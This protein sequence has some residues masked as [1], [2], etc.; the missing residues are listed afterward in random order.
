[1]VSHRTIIDYFL[2]GPDAVVSDSTL[3][4]VIAACLYWRLWTVVIVYI[5]AYLTATTFL[6][7]VPTAFV[8]GVATGLVGEFL[9]RVDAPG[10]AA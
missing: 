2:E 8:F 4:W 3:Q 5:T 1:M 7:H 9:T 10:G 6:S